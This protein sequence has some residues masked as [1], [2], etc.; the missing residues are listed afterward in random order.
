MNDSR[1][2]SLSQSL[3]SPSELSTQSTQP[4]GG[5]GDRRGGTNALFFSVLILTLGAYLI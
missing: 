2:E 3:W 5:V 1:G 4:A